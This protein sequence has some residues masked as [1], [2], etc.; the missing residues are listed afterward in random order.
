VILTYKYRIKDRSARKT[1]RRHAYAVN[2]VWNYCC[3]LQRD[4]QS[5]YRAGASKRKWPTTFDL[6][7]LTAGSSTELGIHAG[8]INEVC[9]QFVVS[10]NKLRRPPRF[11]SSGGA[12]RSL[13]W[14]P[15]RAKE[16]R[17]ESNAITYRGKKFRFFGSS[18]RPLP[19]NL[20]SGAF[21]E[22]ACGRWYVCFRVE[23]A[24]DLTAGAGEVG[25]DLGL[26]TLA[27]LSDGTTI[28]PVR[29][30]R[31]NAKALATARRAGNTKRVRAIHAKIANSRRDH[32][33][34]TSYKIANEN[35]FIAVGNVSAA[36]LMQTKMAKSVSD[37]GWSAFRYQLR[38]K[39]SRHGARYVEVDER[40]TSQTCSSCGVIPASSPKGMG[41]LGIRRWEC[42]GC[43][44]VHDRDVNAAI[45]ILNVALSAQRHADESRGVA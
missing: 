1:L 23:A 45:N 22:D 12:K 38:Y 41:A 34:K 7:K 4:I 2:Q 44:A 21:V 29:H 30:Y 33:H 39:A 10:R 13:G 24:C 27:A 37:A 19:P 36:R 28:D 31:K 32:L 40:W 42:S 43:G 17:A 8:T 6:H 11:R 26:S 15:F 25:I 20:K 3:A 35:I 16:F 18:S 14:V 9:R 5:R